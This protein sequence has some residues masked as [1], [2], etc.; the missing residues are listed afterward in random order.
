MILD[1]IALATRKRIEAK[2][3]KISFEEI[4]KM[5][6][7]IAKTET[8]FT[9]SLFCW[10]TVFSLTIMFRK[11]WQNVHRLFWASALFWLSFTQLTSGARITRP[12]IISN[13]F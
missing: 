1:D 8:E 4:K 3:K 6:M 13:N 7:E 9:F 5:A 2:K 10:G 12:W 11:C